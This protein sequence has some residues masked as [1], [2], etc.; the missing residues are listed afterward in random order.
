[1]MVLLFFLFALTMLLAWFG[2]RKAAITLFLINLALCALWFK[3][4]ASD[5][6]NIEL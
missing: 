1:M 5:H 6:I 4:H 3:H 2:K